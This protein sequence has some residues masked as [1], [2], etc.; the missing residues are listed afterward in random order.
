[1]ALKSFL[2]FTFIFISVNLSFS[3]TFEVSGII[4]DLNTNKKLSFV[5]V[6]VA[7]TAFGTTADEDGKYFIRLNPGGY[8]LVFSYIG[9]FTDTVSVYI[10]DKDIERNIFLKPSELLTEEINVYGEDPAYEIIRKAIAYKKKFKSTLNEYEYNAY[11]KFVIRSNQSSIVEQDVVEDAEKKDKTPIF[12]ILESETKGYFKKP[13]QE[14]QIVTAKRETA[15]ITRGFAL[16]LIVNFYNEDLDFNEFK[17]PTPLSD[18][19]F[20][21]YDYRLK[22]TTSID[23]LIIY[24]IEVINTS[25]NQPL[26][27]GT[28]YIAD[29]IFAL[30]RV[31][32]STNE[33][34]KPLG[35]N[36]LNFKQ[37][38]STFT[39]Y[40][41]TGTEYWMPT[42]VQ[43][44]ADGSFAA[45]IKF[46][47]EVFSIVSHYDLNKKAPKGIFDEFVVKVLPDAKKDST[48]WKKNQLIKN[49]TEEK[50]AYTKIEVETKKAEKSINLSPF[51]IGYGKLFS[52]NT[53]DYYH[54]NRVE[55]S[56]L[57]FNLNYLSR[58]RRVRVNSE[59]TYGTSDNSGKFNISYS[60]RFL[61]DRRFIL[62]ADIYKKL[63][64]LSTQNF[65]GVTRFYNTV[66]SL[67]N[68]LDNFDYYYGTGYNLEARYKI[69]P[70]LGV[71]MNYNQEGQKTA[72][73]NTNYSFFKKDENYNANPGINDAYQRVFGVGFN[74]DP[75]EFRS[76]DWGDGDISRIKYSR[77]PSL[78]FGFKFSG[79]NVFTSTYNYR[80]FTASIKGQNYFNRFINIKYIIGGE[81]MTGDVPFQ[82]L[83][84]FKTS[85]GR[86]DVGIGFN[87]LNYQEFLGDKIFYLNFANNF[88]KILWGGIPFMSKWNLIGL[89]NMGRNEI[90]NSNY[91]L[92]PYK[93]FTIS[94]GMYMEAGFG[95]SRI[96]DILR[97]DFAW[98]LNNLYNNSNK[99]F[100]S[101]SLDTF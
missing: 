72:Y 76:I 101:I 54:F 20:N 100:I 92:A 2:I 18:N 49:T 99:V 68:K 30:M 10:E 95:V 51:S 60:Q 48:F 5:T 27:K 97:I 69:I 43:I 83:A 84:Y 17:I 91:E 44:F 34:A 37:K 66:T 90:S 65:L 12:G 67:F 41:N 25:E 89:F 80:A 73:K 78:D 33:A 93:S 16:P 35:I 29:S 52:S 64:P 36:K 45:I 53:V 32:L 1:M 21:H 13:D 47:A 98:R 74:I 11:S 8:K 26:L 87:A 86:L 22:G 38:F 55:G 63:F 59:Y 96:L 14:K 31:D 62:S 15:N 19:A 40:K 23:S 77:Y 56:A 70:Q 79:I 9:Y 46:E 75:N 58:K 82:S 57:G 94:Q 24:K 28:I 50:K 85:T 7:D 39:D 3:Q 6:K 88:G 71:Y 4:A 81:L 42:D 61:N